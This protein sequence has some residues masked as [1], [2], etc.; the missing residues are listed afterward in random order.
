MSRIKAQGN[1]DN[2]RRVV[3]KG[4]AVRARQPKEK[5]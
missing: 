1:T 2:E 4:E 3:E 5:K